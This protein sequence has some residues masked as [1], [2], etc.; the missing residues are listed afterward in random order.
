M[1]D[2]NSFVA[3][4]IYSISAYGAGYHGAQRSVIIAL[5]M[6]LNGFQHMRVSFCWHAVT[7]HIDSQTAW[8]TT[9]ERIH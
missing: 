1:L 8:L 9:F 5:E 2:R 7:I 4:H 3:S 6:V